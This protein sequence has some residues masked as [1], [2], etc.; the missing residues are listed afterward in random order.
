MGELLGKNEQLTM[1]NFQGLSG[2]SG[3]CDI[4]TANLRFRANYIDPNRN[5]LL[6]FDL[7]NSDR[8]ICTV[9]YTLH[10]ASLR[11]TRPISKL[12]HRSWTLVRNSKFEIPNS[13]SPILFES[14]IPFIS[15][16]SLSSRELLCWLTMIELSSIIML[17]W[18]SQ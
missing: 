12:W 8:T 4:S 11:V 16:A 5:A 9:E 1:R 18:S 13:T 14:I 17:W 15:T 7:A 10:E 6:Q 3:R 2:W